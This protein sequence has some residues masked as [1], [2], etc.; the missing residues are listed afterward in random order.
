[1]MP[2]S[3]RA[4]LYAVAK[5]LGDINAVRRGTVGKRVARRAA[6]KVAGRTLRRLI[7]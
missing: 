6:G 7:R 5:L 1:M 4:M 3:I 2:R